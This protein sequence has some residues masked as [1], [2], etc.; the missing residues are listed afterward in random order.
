MKNQT[1]RLLRE[2][3]ISFC[4]SCAELP[5]PDE[6]VVVQTFNVVAAPDG[7][8]YEI[9]L[10]SGSKTWDLSGHGLL[11]GSR[12][13]LDFLRSMLLDHSTSEFRNILR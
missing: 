3:E 11:M 8:H 2:I 13:K 10:V 9:T 6:L 12:L 7:V 1:E 5:D 4:D